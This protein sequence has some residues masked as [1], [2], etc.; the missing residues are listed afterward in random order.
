M[1]PTLSAILWRVM[2]AISLIAS[3]VVPVAARTPGVTTPEV[4][5]AATAATDAAMPCH[6]APAAKPAPAPADVPCDDG[7]CPQ[8]DCDPGACRVAGSLMATSTP[9]LPG[10]PPAA[11]LVSFHAPAVAG[12]PVGEPLRPPIS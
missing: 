2:L 12:V 8:P 11:Y 5:T 3:P 7:C 1:R 9:L 4:A 6:G 10:L